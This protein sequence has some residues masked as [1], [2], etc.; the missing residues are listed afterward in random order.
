MCAQLFRPLTPAQERVAKVVATGKSYRE[1]GRI[2]NL[3]ART[4]ETYV[5]RIDD[6]IDR[7][8]EGS[9]PYRRVFLWARAEYKIAA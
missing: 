1:I 6:L 8:D 2:L 7:D 4:V 3:S 9:T 5:H